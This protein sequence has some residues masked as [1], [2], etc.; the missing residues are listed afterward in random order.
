MTALA[1]WIALSLPAGM[2]AGCCIR[3]GME[4]PP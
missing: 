2:L 3:A 1:L 4:T